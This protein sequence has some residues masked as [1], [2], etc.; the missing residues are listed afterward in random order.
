MRIDDTEEGELADGSEK[1]FKNE[2]K[3][4]EK[5]KKLTTSTNKKSSLANETSKTERKSRAKNEIEN[6]GNDEDFI[7]SKLFGTKLNDESK[8]KP[9]NNKN[10]DNDLL[11]TLK[12]NDNDDELDD[13]DKL[14]KEKARKMQAKRFAGFE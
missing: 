3:Q 2:K 5:P 12:F 14:L 6:Q 11:K 1:R 9:T 7:N 4:E 8:I 13:F 10:N